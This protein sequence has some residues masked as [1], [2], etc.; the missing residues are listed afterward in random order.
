MSEDNKNSVARRRLYKV[1][2]E[3]W[4]NNE[5]LPSLCRSVLYRR[6]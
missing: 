1:V 5:L 3:E 4:L 6:Y 2:V